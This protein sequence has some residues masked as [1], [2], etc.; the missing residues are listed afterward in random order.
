MH[1]HLLL[2]CSNILASSSLISSYGYIPIS[3]NRTDADD[4]EYEVRFHLVKNR[5]LDEVPF[6]C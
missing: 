4:R 6:D 5:T 3:E 2:G 1:K